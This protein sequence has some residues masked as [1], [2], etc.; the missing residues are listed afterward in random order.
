MFK[1]K[2][3]Y[4]T[5][6]VGVAFLLAAFY[7]G[8]TVRNYAIESDKLA[9]GQSFRVVL[10]S[11]LHG[12]SYGD[13]QRVL[14][15]KVREQEPDLIALPGDILDR[16]RSPDA[17]FE[18]IEGLQGIA[19]MYFVTGNH[20]ID[21]SDDFVRHDVKDVFR[22][23]GVTV[24]ENETA[25]VNVNGVDL[26]VG[27]L[28]DPLRTY[29]ENIQASWEETALTSLGDVDTETAFS[30]LLSHRAEQ[31]ETYAALP[32]DLVLSGHAHGG[33]VRIPY[34]LNGLYAPDQGFFPKYAGG[35]YEH[36]SFTHVIGRGFNYSVSV[37]RVFNPPEIVVIDVTGTGA[38]Q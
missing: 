37:P 6:G 25:S 22:S 33:Q 24:L 8:L 9:S 30:L 7:N 19:P 15:D 10:L 17:S 34:L 1:G 12:Y 11:D 21:G 18:L 2:R 14:I 20:E 38:P 23:Y 3:K 26:L 4:V 35:L 28:E 13:D 29:T 36:E 27:G 16:F 5:I 32:F 31:V